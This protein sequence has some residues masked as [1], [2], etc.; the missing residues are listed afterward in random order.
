MSAYSTLALDRSGTVATIT[1]SRPE[2]LNTFDDDLHREFA[3][4]L[5]ELRREPDLRAIVLASTGKAFSV[6]GSFELMMAAHDSPRERSRI[7]D[8]A[9]RIIN[10]LL[11][12]V[13]PV[14]AA[15]HGDAVG[16]GATVVLACDAVV[17]ARTARLGDPHVRIGLVAGDGG[18]VMWPQA[19]GMLRAR[20]HLLTGDL[21]TAEEAFAMG[22]VTDLVDEPGDVLR[23]AR[24]IADRISELP[25]MAVQGT[26]RALNAATRQR[27]NEVFELSLANEELTLGSDDL[28]EA[29][30]A[31]GGR[32]PG[33]YT[34]A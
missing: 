5:R 28:V 19:A 20:R 33:R 34:G 31:H 30:Q 15:V 14:V 23:Q 9:R 12:L 11:E 24:S 32:R 1:L 27:A 6:G 8:D 22:L 10:E 2:V 4:V 17:A 29:I 25:P 13:V 26:K 21:L 3:A 7:V 18:C 16:L